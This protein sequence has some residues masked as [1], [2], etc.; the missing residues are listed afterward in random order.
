MVAMEL[1]RNMYSRHDK[2]M[3]VNLANKT[4]L[5]SHSKIANTDVSKLFVHYESRGILE[6]DTKVER[7]ISMEI[8]I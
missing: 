1:L 8:M 4:K 6:T 7:S 5:L 2:K 3:C